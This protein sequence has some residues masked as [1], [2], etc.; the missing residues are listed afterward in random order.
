MGHLISSENTEHQQYFDSIRLLVDPLLEEETLPNSFID[1]IA[2]LQSVEDELIDLLPTVTDAD[3]ANIEDARKYIVFKTA[4]EL[5]YKF[6]QVIQEAELQHITRYAEID[7]KEPIDRLNRRVNRLETKLG[8]G[9]SP[10]AT[11]DVGVL[12][13]A[14]RLPRG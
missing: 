12:T 9:A 5:M 6:R 14:S 8:I 1:T 10:S 4:I 2:Y 13:T 11:F 7:F 3:F